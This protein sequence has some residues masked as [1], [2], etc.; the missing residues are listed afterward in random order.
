MTALE[1]KPQPGPQ[2]ALLACPIEDVMYGG[3]VGGGKT[4]GMLL[5]ALDHMLQY[6][7]AAN[8]LFVRRVGKNLKNVIQQ[9]MTLYPKFGGVYAERTGWTFP[10]GAKMMFAHMWDER[11]AV[12]N[13]Q[14]DEYTWVCV[15][16]MGQYPTDKAPNYLK[17]RIRSSAGVPCFFRATAN[18]G[19][20]GHAWIKARYISPA[21][22]GYKVLI[23]PRSQERRVFI[24]ARLED[25]QILMRSDPKY[26]SRLQGYGSPEL[27]RALR[28]GDWDAIAGAFFGDVWRPEKQ[29]IKP[30]EI[31]ATW[32]RRRAFDWG[33]AK[34]SALGLY[35]ISD[36]TQP[37]GFNR[38][39]PRNSVVRFGEWYTCAKGDDGLTIPDQGLR[40]VNDDIGY[41][42]ANRSKYINWNGCVADPSIFTSAGGPSVFDQM[43]AGAKKLGRA[44][45]FRGA[46]N[47]RVPGWQRFR[48]YLEAS[49]NDEIENP[50]LWIFDNCLEFARTVPV[51]QMDTSKP[52]D[53][54]T[55]SEDHIADECRYL[56]Q[57]LTMS[58]KASGASKLRM[59]GR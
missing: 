40:L 6:G 37:E 48:Q 20:V 28:F 21:P 51:L 9:S 8:C 41:G 23:D 26:E 1:I 59:E 13:F 49:S 19:G 3:A 27:V 34:P 7:S 58:G 11:A 57:S 12:L 14:G 45:V 36:G 29:I 47:A 35:A 10:N 30:F 43:N 52:D 56:L 2:A 50:G 39:I 22:E 44:L 33:S 54:D 17:T 32:V 16:E 46:D 25:N 53:I 42:I 18:P 15:E 5:D 24:P 31:P 55:T 38:W 4:F